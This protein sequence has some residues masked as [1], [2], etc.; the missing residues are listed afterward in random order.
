VKHERGWKE[1]EM[2]SK[3]RKGFERE[4]ER[5][6]GTREGGKGELN[7]GKGRVK[8]RRRKGRGGGRDWLK[9][10]RRI[11]NRRKGRK[12]ERGKRNEK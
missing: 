11:E 7:A 4:W 5:K 1:I 3:G 10:E 6:K 9:E 2:G 12:Q 8:G